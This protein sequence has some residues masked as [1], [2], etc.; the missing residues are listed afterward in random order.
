MTEEYEVGYSAQAEVDLAEIEA[1]LSDFIPTDAAQLI[2]DRIIAFCDGWYGV[3]QKHPTGYCFQDEPHF[4]VGVQLPSRG[5]QDAP[6]LTIQPPP[7]TR[8]P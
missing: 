3:R 4:R 8:Q 2:V 1:Y 7:P 6:V 5:R